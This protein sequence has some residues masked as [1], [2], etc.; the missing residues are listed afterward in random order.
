[1][2]YC[3]ILEAVN[4][5]DSV[6]INKNTK[7][8]IMYS[9]IPILQ[10]KFNEMVKKYKLP[11]QNKAIFYYALSEEIEKSPDNQELKD[12]L[13]YAI[14]DTGFLINHF[15]ADMSTSELHKRYKAYLK[16]F[17]KMRTLLEEQSLL[18]TQWN[19]ICSRQ[20]IPTFQPLSGEFLSI[21]EKETS[22]LY[23]FYCKFFEI[24]GKNAPELFNNLKNFVQLSYSYPDY[25]KIAPFFFYQIMVKH[26]KR[27]ATTENLQ[28]S[29]K[30]LWKYKEYRIYCN[31]KKN[32]YT[33]QKYAA[34]FVDLCDYYKS[35]DIVNVL[36]CKYAFYKT[37]N[38]MDWLDSYEPYLLKEC[39]MP[40]ARF[41]PKLKL[42]YTEFNAPKKFEPDTLFH[43]TDDI[44][45]EFTFQNQKLYDQ[46]GDT[47]LYYLLEDMSGFV[48]QMA[49][50][51]ANANEL[52]KTVQKI[53][54]ATEVGKLFS[55]KIPLKYQLA[56]VYQFMLTFL[57]GFVNVKIE[58][59]LL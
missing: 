11:M 27:L 1:M 44:G 53:Y 7:G 39:Q 16:R 8:K 37:S 4:F 14:C 29:P 24:Q 6:K 49:D 5:L 19:A 58:S 52:R 34:L 48:Y 30:S 18:D 41:I 47:I 28:F 3:T 43:I 26:T 36:L 22:V 33:Y 21:C 42:S 57:D 9:E 23:K 50:L 20:T 46:I 51:Y 25:H 15:D 35:D 54:D 2:F 56:D 59:V 45:L 12:L 38:L 32:Y 55:N 10:E 40:L 17:H 31:N 13:I